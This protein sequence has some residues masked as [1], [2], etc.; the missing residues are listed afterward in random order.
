MNG[1]FPKDK[2][3]QLIKVLEVHKESIF[4]REP[5]DFIGKQINRSRIARLPRLNKETNGPIDSQKSNHERCLSH[6]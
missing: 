2:L 3:L 5:V 4:F 1:A 6:H